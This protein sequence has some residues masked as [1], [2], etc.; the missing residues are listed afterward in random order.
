MDIAVNI[1]IK[2][3]MHENRQPFIR[4]DHEVELYNT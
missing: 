3:S 1:I 4:Q 2:L